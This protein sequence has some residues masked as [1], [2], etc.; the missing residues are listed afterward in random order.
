[1]NSTKPSNTSNATSQADANV[2]PDLYLINI[3]NFVN[4]IANIYIIPI[5]S[6]T[7]FIFNLLSLIVFLNP[8]LKGK[9]YKYFVTKSISEL[10]FLSIGALYPLFFCSSCPSYLSLAWAISVKYGAGLVIEIAFTSINLCELA[11]I[12][13]RLVLLYQI[14]R[15]DFDARIV[16]ASII[17]VSSAPF[18]PNIFSS[19]ITEIMPG[20]FLFANTE[21]GSTSSFQWYQGLLVLI[22]NNI[23][24]L[25]LITMNIIL[26]HKFKSHLARKRTLIS[27]S[28][29]AISLI[30]NKSIKTVSIPHL[31]GIAQQPILDEARGVTR[32]VEIE[33]SAVATNANSSVK[34][35]G[36][37]KSTSR[38]VQS[39]S[40][41]DPERRVTI[42]VIVISFVFVISR[43]FETINTIPQA[44]YMYSGASKTAAFYSFNFVNNL[45]V[46]I[47]S[48]ANF[49]IFFAFNKP[50]KTC[51]IE[52][53]RAVFRLNRI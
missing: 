49:F 20:K 32:N 24:I 1:M 6:V 16:I 18:L 35:G 7:A 33:P 2:L 48:V 53:T 41:E 3:Y 34:N 21:F 22:E 8:K 52:M 37:R 4:K 30:A 46:Y 23:M 29:S 44:Y 31:A 9:L 13:D 27:S 15:F 12:Y 5:I 51:L 43:T 14:K 42:M 36:L 10:V 50:F 45:I 25:V 47:A 11:I 39:V 26:V 28:K 17:T 40:E 19:Y 38:G